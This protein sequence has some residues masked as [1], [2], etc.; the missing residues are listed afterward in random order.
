MRSGATS[1]DNRSGENFSGENRSGKN[2]S[3]NKKAFFLSQAEPAEVSKKQ[4]KTERS[5]QTDI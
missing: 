3:G 4:G 2:C 5:K 1:E